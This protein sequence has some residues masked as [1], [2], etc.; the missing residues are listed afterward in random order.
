[1]AK[2]QSAVN[3]KKWLRYVYN[4]IAKPS[5]QEMGQYG[6]VL[7]VRWLHV[8]AT[9]QPNMDATTMML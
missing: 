7:N 3:A 2:V 1:M 9:M 4:R 6:A 8:F 5:L